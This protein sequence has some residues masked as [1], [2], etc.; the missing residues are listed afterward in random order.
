MGSKRVLNR[1][2]SSR[3]DGQL[4]NCSI[5]EVQYKQRLRACREL[6]HDW[7]SGAVSMRTRATRGGIDFGLSSWAIWIHLVI[8]WIWSSLV[9]PWCSMFFVHI[10]I[11]DG[12]KWFSA[13]HAQKGHS[14]FVSN[15][16]F[17]FQVM[18]GIGSR[19][20]RAHVHELHWTGHSVAHKSFDFVS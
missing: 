14:E 20:F 7:N 10:F 3:S 12:Q 4:K 18:V 2:F 6:L 17:M 13:Q 19:F 1:F 9:F 15:C 5:H 11:V 8:E 16:S